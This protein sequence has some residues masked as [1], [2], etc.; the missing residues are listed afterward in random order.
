MINQQPKT[1][2]NERNRRN[3]EILCEITGVLKDRGYGIAENLSG[4]KVEEPQ[5]NISGEFNAMGILTHA[6][7]IVLGIRIPFPKIWAFPATLWIDNRTR[8]AEPNNHWVLDVYGREQLENA[9][10][11]GEQLAKP[12]GVEVTSKVY[13]DQLRWRG[14]RLE[15]PGLTF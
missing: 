7:P 8:G 11:L 12:Y 10:R 2:T 5:P 9:Q 4:R 13:V 14:Q 1:I 6:T 15:F 3:R